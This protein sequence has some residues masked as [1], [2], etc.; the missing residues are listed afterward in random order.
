MK[1]EI[2]DKKTIKIKIEDEVDL[3]YL[4]KIVNVGDIIE[5][6]D[7]RTLKFENEKEK[8]KIKI[9][10]EIENIKF[11]EYKDSL[12]IS[13]KII[14]SND[15]DSIGHYHT[16]DIRISTEFTLYKKEEIKKY[17]EKI[18][19]KSSRKKEDIF[20]IS[21]DNNDIAL[22]IINNGIKIIKEEYYKINKGDPEEKTKLYKIFSEFLDTIR[23]YDIKFLCIIGPLFY[24]E[25]FY[26]YI[27]DKL[28]IKNIK[29][30]K[31]SNGGVNGIYEFVRR[32]EYYETLK[33]LEILEIN[34]LIE[35]VLYLMQKNMVA[36]GY[37]EVYNNAMYNNI[38]YVLI[39]EECFKK[40]KEENN[41]DKIIN[42]FNILDKIDAE[43][44]FVNNNANNFEL[45]DRFCIVGKLRYKL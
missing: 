24:P 10:I 41:I 38:E 2:I 15:K 36:F 31:V 17:E 32:T 19:E 27:K 28:N 34:K 16:F 21:I 39:S 26:D 30:Y 33:N 20:V 35:E 1:Y 40:M 37:D 5:G 29:I 11:S 9:K 23:D 22:G 25:E 42:L 8:K 14:D 44:Y 43:I 13:G 7:Y 3:L 12:R 45:I 6:Y 18:L 4:Y